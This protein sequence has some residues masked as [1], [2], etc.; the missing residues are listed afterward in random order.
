MK[1]KCDNCSRELDVHKDTVM[2]VCPC[3]YTKVI[4]ELKELKNSKK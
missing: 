4:K 1:I 2:I 3:G